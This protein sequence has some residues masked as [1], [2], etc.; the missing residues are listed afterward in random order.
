MSAALTA[1]GFVVVLILAVFLA[2]VALYLLTERETADPQVVDRSAAERLAKARGGRRESLD[3]DGTGRSDSGQQ[4]GERDGQD[5]SENS[6]WGS[7]SRSR[8]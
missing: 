4:T 3:R 7:E 1:R 6:G 2:P 8:E 5:G